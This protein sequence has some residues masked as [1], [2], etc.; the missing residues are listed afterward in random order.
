MDGQNGNGF[1]SA[2]CDQRK[3]AGRIDRETGRLSVALYR[4][5]QLGGIRL[6]IDDVDL[7]VWNLFLVIAVLTTSMESATIAT[8]SVGSIAR[9]TG[10]PTTEFFSGR[11]ATIFGLS[12][13][14]RS[15]TNTESSPGGDTTALPLVKCYLFVVADDHERSRLRDNRIEGKRHCCA[16]HDY[17][18]TRNHSFLPGCSACGSIRIRYLKDF[19]IYEQTVV[20]IVVIRSENK[21]PND[22]NFDGNRSR[23][24]KQPGTR[25]VACGSCV[26]SNAGPHGDA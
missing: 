15:T 24:G 5:D 11:L 13:F 2:I 10:G 18:N 22:L 25:H 20:V 4:A 12:G 16:K 9:F 3:I 7:V 6:E 17:D 1:P 19:K 26:T 14:A 8:E 23:G 21:Q